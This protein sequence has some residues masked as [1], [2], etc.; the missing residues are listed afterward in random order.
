MISK[1]DHFPAMIFDMPNSEYH[2]GDWTK[3]FVS[4]TQLKNILVS[5]KFFNYL[6]IN[7]GNEISLEASM[8]GSVYHSI[9]ASITNT[10][11]LDEFEKEY[12]VF[13]PPINPTTGV[14]YGIATKKYQ[15][16]YQQA[17]AEHPGMESTS[18]AEVDL[19]NTM[20]YKLLNEC[21]S[22][23]E[24]VSQ[25]I[26]WGKAEVSHFVEYEGLG[27]KFRTD[28]KTSRKI[29]DWKTI[30]SKDL[31]EDTITSQINKMNYGFSAAFY[32]FFNHLVTGKW[33][34][35]YWVFQQKEPPYDAV[36]VSADTWA[37]SKIDDESPVY[38][39]ASAIEFENAL[40]QYIECNNSGYYPGAEVFIQPNK[41]G[42]RVMNLNVPTYK[43]N[44]I[45]TFYSK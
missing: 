6:R 21:G 28:L 37:Y 17:I 36:I 29:V 20:I 9:L 19:A 38:M 44:N 33:V 34:E 18:H 25:L 45:K 12:F 23:S 27:F 2:Q 10:G 32:Q 24:S 39:G 14:A 13:D 1:P 42:R 16:A 41:K 40:N 5:P 11:C 7:G 31:H 4:S 35:F 3:D 15:E 26:E 22:T 43:R 8:K 30:S